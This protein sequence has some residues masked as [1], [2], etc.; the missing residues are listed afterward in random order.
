MFHAVIKPRGR[1][2]AG[3]SLAVK[4]TAGPGLA[5]DYCYQ[6]RPEQALA[7]LEARIELDELAAFQQEMEQTILQ[8]QK[9]FSQ[10][11]ECCFAPFSAALS[12]T[13]VYAMLEKEGQDLMNSLHEKLD[14]RRR[15]LQLGLTANIRAKIKLPT[16]QLKVK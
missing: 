11:V 5:N 6:I 13:G 10:F 4:R 9:D 8:P 16:T 3:D 1:V 15:E 12:K 14:K 7:A 2:P